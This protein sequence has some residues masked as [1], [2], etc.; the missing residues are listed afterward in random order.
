MPKIAPST[1]LGAAPD[2]LRFIESAS[3]VGFARKAF[4]LALAA[5]VGLVLLLYATG[6]AFL[7]TLFFAYIAA[8]ACTAATTPVLATAYRAHALGQLMAD[9]AGHADL[10]RSCRDARL[11]IGVASLSLLA[12]AAHFNLTA[13]WM[14]GTLVM[15]VDLWDP[16][17]TR[18]LLYAAVL[19]LC[20]LSITDRLIARS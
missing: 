20:A 2:V 19:G 4:M 8:A 14:V 12:V 16:M 1:V 3:P 5:P 13:L 15:G 7:A 9:H 17:L 10:A 18:W 6:M 11:C